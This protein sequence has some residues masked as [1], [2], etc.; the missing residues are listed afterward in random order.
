MTR[1]RIVITGAASGVGAATFAALAAS[2]CDCLAVDRNTAAGP[3][4]IGC[5]LADEASIAA[6]CEAIEGPIDGVAYVAGAPG[7]LAA[8]TVL[9]VNYLGARRFIETL[10]PK[11]REGASIVLVSSLAARRCLWEPARLRA[12]L[13]VSDWAEALEAFA[14]RE[15]SGGEAYELSKRLLLAWLPH[16]AAG[17]LG[18]RFRFNVVTPGPVETPLLPAFRESMGVDRIEAAKT[19]I[20]RHARAEEIAAPIVFLLDPSAS[21]VN[22]VEI[23]ADGGLYALRE[24]LAG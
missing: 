24:A 13:C 14:A 21:W 22:G 17:G 23:V 2:G 16:A 6:A 18:R 20:G 4:T 8:E 5:D 19:L 10:T 3:D 11:F 15:L 12:A 9:R 1:R 7:T